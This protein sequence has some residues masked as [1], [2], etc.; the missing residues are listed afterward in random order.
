MLIKYRKFGM[1]NCSE[2]FMVMPRG[3]ACVYVIFVDF[4]DYICWYLLIMP[5]Y[6][7]KLIKAL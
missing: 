5:F 2:K 7:I 6:G 3:L 4:S 1:C